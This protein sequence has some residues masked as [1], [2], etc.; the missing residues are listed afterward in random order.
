MLHQVANQAQALGRVDQF[1]HIPLVLDQ[2]HQEL[3]AQL[4]IHH[5][6]HPSKFDTQHT[7]NQP[8]TNPTQGNL[9]K[10]N[11]LENPVLSVLGVLGLS[12]LA[13]EMLTTS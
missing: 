4:R 3:K 6:R 1:S 7:I 9:S 8:N 12:N 10:F 11:E 5:H 2:L 13:W